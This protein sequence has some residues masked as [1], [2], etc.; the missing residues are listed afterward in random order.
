MRRSDREI[1]E[2]DEIVDVIKRCDVCRLAFQDGDY[3]YILPL[4]FGVQTEKEQITLFFH[5]ALTGQKMELM[6]RDNRVSFEMD[7]AH[8]LFT[9]DREMS[10]SMAYESVMGHGRIEMVPE[11][12]KYDA[13]VCLMEH[14]HKGDFPFDQRVIPRT[15]VY[16]LVVETVTGKRRKRKIL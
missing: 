9:D 5:S 11:I 3:P 6:Q 1:K 12:E 8:E 4:N 16:K 13:L 14:Y 2:F 15:A 7:C 10:C